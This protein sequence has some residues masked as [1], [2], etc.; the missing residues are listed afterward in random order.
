MARCHHPV[1]HL[2][3]FI[4]SFTQSFTKCL[5]D[6][7]KLSCCLCFIQI[8]MFHAKMPPKTSLANTHGSLLQTMKSLCGMFYDLSLSSPPRHLRLC[9]TQLQLPCQCLSDALSPP[10]PWL[11]HLQAIQ[12]L[13]LSYAFN[14]VFVV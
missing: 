8:L 13:V 14:C 9:M 11:R 5:L 2:V 1:F 12:Y 6:M 7:T 10:Q 3:L 4:F